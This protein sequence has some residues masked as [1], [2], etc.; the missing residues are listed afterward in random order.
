MLSKSEL[1]A[2]LN[3]KP[4]GTFLLRFSA[5]CIG[6]YAV[7]TMT[8]D[9]IKSM[10]ISHEMYTGFSFGSREYDSL[11]AIVFNKKKDFGL[12]TPCEN[13]PFEKIFKPPALSRYSSFFDD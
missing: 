12:I 13:N 7:S 2:K 9:G 3:G 5:S 10:L 4:K 1:E 11:D 8:R 6:S